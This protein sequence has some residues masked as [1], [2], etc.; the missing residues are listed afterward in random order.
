MDLAGM[1]RLR[2]A[3]S[4]IDWIGGRKSAAA[5]ARQIA[6]SFP[7]A[8]SRAVAVASGMISPPGRHSDAPADRKR[9]IP[10][11]FE[12]QVPLDGWMVDEMSVVVAA[13]DQAAVGMRGGNR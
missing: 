8:K 11:G 9:G 6:S 5:I 13:D 10:G 3:S 7:S 4:A 1:L 2:N 12:A